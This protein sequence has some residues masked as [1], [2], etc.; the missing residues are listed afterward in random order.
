MEFKPSLKQYFYILFLPLTLI[1]LFAAQNYAFNVWLDI[2]EKSYTLRL[3]FVSFALGAVIYG[4]SLL[5]LK[6]GKYIYLFFASFIVSLIFVAQF[7]YYRYSESFLGVSALK[8]MGQ[9]PSVAGTAKSLL[10]PE[11]LVFCANIFIVLAAFFLTFRKK[12]TELALSKWGKVIIV[13]LMVFIVFF[14]YKFLL[15]AEKK[16][17]GNT[18]RLYKDVYDL[19]ALVGKMGIINF[20]IEDAVKYFS[21][22]KITNNEKSFLESWSKNRITSETGGKY[23]G[24]AQGRNIILIYAESLE[25]AVI[26][27]KIAGKAITP[28][29]NKIAS[30]GL[31]FNNYYALVGHGNTADAE[32]EALNSLYPLANTVVF[33]DYAKNKYKALPELLRNYGY[34]T[35]SFHGDVPTFWN[36]SNIYPGLG[37]DKSFDINDYIVSRPVG[38]G[39][40]ELGDKD[41]FAQSAPKLQGLEQPFMATFITISSHTP[42]I[43]PDD[44][45]TLAIPSDTDLN[46]N[47]QEYLQSIHY[48]DGAVGEFIDEIKKADLYNN[49]IIL[50]FGDHGSY[51]NISSALGNNKNTLPSLA[52]SQVPLII[53]VPGTELQGTINTPASHLDIYPT[54]TN[55]LGIPAPKTILGQDILNTK[56]PVVT[57]FNLISGGINIILTADLIYEANK[58]GVYEYGA[59]I[60]APSKKFL[61]VENCKKLYS[62]QSDIIKASNIIIRGDLLDMLNATQ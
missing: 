40:S 27:Q 46:K 47:Q 19:N 10:T 32:F 42:F 37:Y 18:S 21:R 53:L 25:N 8:Y 9:A 15:D 57:R 35:Y 45:K 62:Q 61:P 34:K 48:M 20:S 22:N 4:P 14:G 7:L 49:S 28:N 5:F 24:Q 52:N 39:P 33:V 26:N 12:Y 55:L 41:F 30:E 2:A 11:L 38:Q 51:T 36:R 3:F 31:Y 13:I 56:N 44:L 17:W 59:C 43:L 58:N 54:I 1:L 23:F 29:L 6:K 16:E 50:L 60:E